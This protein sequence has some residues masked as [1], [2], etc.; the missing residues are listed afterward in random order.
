MGLNVLCEVRVC[1][2]EPVLF[3]GPHGDRLK[4]GP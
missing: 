4:I 3:R 2:R 1:P